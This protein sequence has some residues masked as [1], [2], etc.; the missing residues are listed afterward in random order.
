[1]ENLQE[2]RLSP[3]YKQRLVT[4]GTAF[5]LWTIRHHLNI[6]TRVTS[7][8]AQA[9]IKWYATPLAPR[10][11]SSFSSRTSASGAGAGTST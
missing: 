1:V 9:L 3:A 4:A 8:L 6:D 10:F 11:S 2:D 5:Y 7:P